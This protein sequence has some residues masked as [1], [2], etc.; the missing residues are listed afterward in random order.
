MVF[1]LVLSKCSHN[2]SH[3]KLFIPKQR[4]KS[5]VWW[6]SQT[7]FLKEMSRKVISRERPFNK[8]TKKI[9]A[10][11]ATVGRNFR[12]TFQLY[13]CHLPSV[14]LHIWLFICMMSHCREL[15]VL[16][17]LYL[18]RALSSCTQFDSLCLYHSFSASQP[19][20]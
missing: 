12:L 19:S 3:A 16:P 6:K 11:A 17:L 9:Q 4:Q 8:K 13:K 5:R 7:A 18:M 20:A 15:S 14:S 2:F 1:F 10:T